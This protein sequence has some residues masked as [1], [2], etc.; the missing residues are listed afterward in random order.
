MK[1]LVVIFSEVDGKGEPTWRVEFAD[2]AKAYHW[3]TRKK[4][5]TFDQVVER[6]TDEVQMICGTEI[7]GPEYKDKVFFWLPRIKPTAVDNLQ[8]NI[9]GYENASKPFH[10]FDNTEPVLYLIVDVNEYS[11]KRF[12]ERIHLYTDN[13]PWL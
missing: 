8:K 5:M 13:D 4:D 10:S 2:F 3:S 6:A 9:I 12:L 11:Y 7:Y 1:Y